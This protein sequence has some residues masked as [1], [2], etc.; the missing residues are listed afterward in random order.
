M[1]KFLIILIISLFSLSV[2]SQVS[3]SFNVNLG[4]SYLNGMIGGELQLGHIAFSGGYFISEYE[5]WSMAVSLYETEWDESSF[6]ISY[7]IASTG[8]V[9]ESPYGIILS[10]TNIAMFGLRFGGDPMNLK[11]GMGYQWCEYDD[12]L[13]WEVTLGIVLDW[14]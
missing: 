4:Y 1:K 2:Y 7:G 11:A 13:T 14:W 9:N 8:Y 5:S 10:P 3:G 12:G 6:Y